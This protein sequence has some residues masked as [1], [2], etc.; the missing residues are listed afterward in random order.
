MDKDTKAERRRAAGEGV[1]EFA[2]KLIGPDDF[3]AMKG[4]AVELPEVASVAR[5]EKSGRRFRG[6]KQHRGI[7]G[8]QALN[9]DA[10]VNIRH[11]IHLFE[12]FRQPGAL[13]RR[14]QISPRL[15]HTVAR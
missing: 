7:L 1:L 14:F 9:H 13:W 5:H 6:G 11:D 3:Y 4:L 10:G 12:E 2:G 15:L 8:G